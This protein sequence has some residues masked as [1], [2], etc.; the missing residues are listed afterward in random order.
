M[1]S[2]LKYEPAPSVPADFDRQLKNI[3]PRCPTGEPYL[4]FTWGMDATEVLDDKI[5]HRYPD[6]DGVYVG[7][8]FWVL[9]GWQSPD[10]YDKT[11]WLE[12]EDVL[13]PW[14]ANGVWDYIET[15][16]DDQG[17]FLNLGS[18]ALQM[19]RSWRHWQSKSKARVLAEL[20]EHRCK[21]QV[22]KEKRWEEQKQEMLDTLV[23][24]Y[25]R[26]ERGGHD[27]RRRSLIG[28]ITGGAY[29]E[30]ASGLLIPTTI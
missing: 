24:D 29:Q 6:P 20:V 15:V 30:T 16:K 10:V 21:L 1:E 11:E 23:R 14:P 3:V 26:V 12:N 4:R 25:S 7:L 2:H 19:A 28:K 22:L 5:L 17:R 27:P 8:P 13:G 18:K 9:E